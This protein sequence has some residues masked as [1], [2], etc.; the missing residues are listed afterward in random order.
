MSIVYLLIVLVNSGFQKLSNY[1]RQLEHTFLMENGYSK[2]LDRL[3]LSFVYELSLS[4]TLSTKGNEVRMHN[5][6]V[7]KIGL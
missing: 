3:L 4:F 7:S 2:D 5:Y 6:M 1:N